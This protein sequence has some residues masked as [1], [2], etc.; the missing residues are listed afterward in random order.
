MFEVTKRFEFDAAHRL[1][2]HKGRCKNIHGH[3][4]IAEVTFGSYCA[5]QDD[6]VVDF[7]ALKKHIGS[8]IDNHWDHA[9]L[10]NKVDPVAI[11]VREGLSGQRLYPT[12]GDPTAEN[13]AKDLYFKILA[14]D[15]GFDI[16]SARLCRV[17]IYETPNSW[18]DFAVDK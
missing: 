11:S 2:R 17:R 6:M 14:L 7:G 4:Y 12:N 1:S 13:M 15:C 3:R 10:L 18:A 9:L 5:N 16:N 8:W